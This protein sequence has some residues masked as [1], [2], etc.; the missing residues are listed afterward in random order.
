MHHTSALIVRRLAALG[1]AKP[2]PQLV[3]AIEA[4]LAPH[5]TALVTRRLTKPMIARCFAATLIE[6]FP[7]VSPEGSGEASPA[8]ASS[9]LGDKPNHVAGTTAPGAANT[10][11]P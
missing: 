4:R 5:V 9:D 10:E 7:K 8:L 3:V 2:T 6:A 11:A 1:V